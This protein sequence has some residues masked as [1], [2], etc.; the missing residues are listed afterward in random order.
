M[1]RRE[2]LCWFALISMTLC[3][4]GASGGLISGDHMQAASGLGWA[5]WVWLIHRSLARSNERSAAEPESA[6]IWD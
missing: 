4:V 6:S 1:S 2:L 3:V 5:C